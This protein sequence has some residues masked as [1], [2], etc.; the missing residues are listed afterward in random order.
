MKTEGKLTEMRDALEAALLTLRTLE[1]DG[2]NIA[3]DCREVI[4]MVEGAMS[5]LS[6]R[7]PRLDLM[8]PTK[9]AG[10]A[11]TWQPEAPPAGSV[12]TSTGSTPSLA[13]A[14]EAMRDK[15]N[16]YNACKC[17]RCSAE[18]DAAMSL[19]ESA[20]AVL[21]AWDAMKKGGCDG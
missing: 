1:A 17:G 20:E 18:C 12:G 14:I 13:D 3:T 11:R 8:G 2:E 15:P 4:R 19:F 9:Y 5:T 7:D 10:P 16:A 6:A 21:A